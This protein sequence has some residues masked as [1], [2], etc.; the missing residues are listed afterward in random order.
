MFF[1]ADPEV[2]HVGLYE[3]DLIERK[4][5]YDVY[6]RPF[7]DVDRAICDGETEGFVKILTTKGTD[8]I[9]GATIVGSHAGDMISEITLAMQS[10]TGLGTI[11]STIHPYP[12][13]AEAIRQCGDIFNRTR[14][15]VFVKRLLKK[16]VA[17]Q[18]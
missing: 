9:V 18:G 17:A 1:L 2:A 8:K 3:N 5:E 4:I 15:T 10:K 6:E 14:L 16:I 12:T 11:A 7:E 13:Q